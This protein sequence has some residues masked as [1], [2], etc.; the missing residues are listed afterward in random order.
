MR[1]LNF[2]N[3]RCSKG[4][5]TIKT[6]CTIGFAKKSLREFVNRLK[7]ADVKKIIDVRLNNTSQL[8]GYAKKE[9]LEFILQLVDIEYEHHPELAPTEEILKNYKNKKISWLDYEAEFNKLLT[10]RNPLNSI[11]F[12]KEMGNIC[13][14]CSEDT[15]KQCHRR[16]LA[17]YFNKKV[18]EWSIKHL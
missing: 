17:E 9:D 6:I 8:A 12:E 15:P 7:K 2:N 16:L 18:T 11:N 3:Y 1:L 14:L 13:L 10:L 4:V 5:G